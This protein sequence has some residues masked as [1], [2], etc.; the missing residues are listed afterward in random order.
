MAVIPWIAANIYG[1][2]TDGPNSFSKTKDQGRAQEVCVHK[3]SGVSS[4]KL[5]YHK[6]L[7]VELVSHHTDHINLIVSA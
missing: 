2:F 6:Y 4:V 1:I 5:T 3:D 7:I